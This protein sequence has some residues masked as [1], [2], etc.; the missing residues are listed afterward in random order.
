MPVTQ[1]AEEAVEP[2]SPAA[3]LRLRRHP[4]FQSQ[5]EAYCR[6]SLAHHAGLDVIER[7]LVSDLGRQSL[8]RAMVI[9]DAIYGEVSARALVEAARVNRTCSRGRVLAF[10]QRGELNGLF[11][12][13][14]AAPVMERRYQLQPKFVEAMA[15]ATIIIV[16]TVA[17]LAPEVSAAAE[18]IVEPR[19]RR[20]FMATLGGLSVSRRDLFAGPEM[21]VTLFLNRDGGE[22]ILEQLIVS[23]PPDRTRLLE[24]APVSRS[25]L[26]R[27][28]VTSRP[29][30]R[31]LL[32]AGE[33]SGHLIVSE[34]SVTVSAVLA[35]DCERHFALI[36]EI[37]RAT[38]LM[39][40]LD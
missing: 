33:D 25:S 18:A 32:E 29:H 39:T 16:Q 7:W 8:S 11:A 20:R 22:R 36:L 15:A 9:L 28:A 24:R 34:R 26:A 23:Q 38:A 12:S 3:F 5:V 21:P 31:R 10:L 4:L 13:D 27:C 37:A 2:L 6:A 1:G 17:K 30:V 14:P 19:F 35:E 40:S